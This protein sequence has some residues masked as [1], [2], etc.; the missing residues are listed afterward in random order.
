MA[1]LNFTKYLHKP[2]VSQIYT[3]LILNANW[4][5]SFS[6]CTCSHALEMIMT[7]DTASDACVLGALSLCSGFKC[8]Q[9]HN[10]SWTDVPLK[11]YKEQSKPKCYHLPRTP[12]F[13]NYLSNKALYSVPEREEV[14]SCLAAVWVFQQKSPSALDVFDILRCSWYSAVNHFS[15]NTKM[16]LWTWGQELLC[17][18][19]VNIEGEDTASAFQEVSF[20][21]EKW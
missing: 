13:N 18:M 4:V 20:H 1:F 14:K 6:P 11:F 10:S 19:K 9:L 7:S 17:I 5:I 16:T 8:S 2:F 21:R 15:Q 3:L 12:Q